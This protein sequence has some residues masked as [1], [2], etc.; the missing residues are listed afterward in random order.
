MGGHDQTLKPF[1]WRAETI[2]PDR[3]IVAR[4][5]EGINRWTYA[6]YADQTRQLANALDSLGIGD[7]D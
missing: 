7:G 1:L 2:Y 3:E 5:H 6:E 4:T